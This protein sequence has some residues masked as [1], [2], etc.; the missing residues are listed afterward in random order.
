IDNARAL[1]CCS[2]EC[3]RSPAH[4]PSQCCT[5]GTSTQDGEVAPATRLTRANISAVSLGILQA[6]AVTL[7]IA[8][9]RAVVQL[10]DCSPPPREVRNSLCSLLI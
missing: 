1:E 3:P 5:V 6:S 7:P 4:N 8:A 2:K 10:P 9:S